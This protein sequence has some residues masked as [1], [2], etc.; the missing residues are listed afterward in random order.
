MSWYYTYGFF[1]GVVSL[2]VLQYNL[3]I[4]LLLVICFGLIGW[5]F[6]IKDTFELNKEARQ[7]ELNS[8]GGKK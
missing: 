8:D 5:I 4:G 7:S 6:D 2:F 1:A 3:I